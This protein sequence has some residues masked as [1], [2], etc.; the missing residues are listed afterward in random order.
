MI[1]SAFSKKTS[2]FLPN[3][4]CRRYKHVAPIIPDGKELIM[5]QFVR[6][7]DIA[8]IKIQLRDLTILKSHG[9][10]FV[11]IDGAA[12][13]HDYNPYLARTCVDLTKHILCIKNIFIQTPLALYKK[14]KCAV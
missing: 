1:I 5:Y 13:P 8:K 6:P 4:I 10:D 12:L 14:I 9:W 3:L 7:G 11:Y 2:K